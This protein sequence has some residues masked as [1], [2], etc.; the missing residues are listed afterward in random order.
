LTVGT[1]SS[2]RGVVPFVLVADLESTIHSPTG[3][4]AG[5]DELMR[6]LADD[7]IYATVVVLGV[8]WFHRSGLRAGLAVAGGALLA[9]A[10]GQ[11]LG[12]LFPESRPFVTDH[13]TPLVAHA[14]DGSF[15]SDHQL[16]LGALVGGCF[17]ASR[18][19]ATAAAIMAL[20]VA[21][22]RVY[23]GI[24]HPVDV[25][26]GFLVGVVCGLAAWAR[27]PSTGSSRVDIHGFIRA[28]TETIA[29]CGH[30]DRSSAVRRSW[31]AR[32]GTTK[33]ARKIGRKLF[34]VARKATV[35]P[36]AASKV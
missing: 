28:V 19:L 32:L 16:V 33:E 29:G 3:H 4:I 14:A 6:L 5:L 2:R 21:A 26:A 9:L 35:W 27:C 15:P 7:L 22:A 31:I 30:R 25:I 36:S 1:S 8:L 17:I 13:F 34:P 24:H 10:L 11:L 12:S 20:L 23:V 18:P